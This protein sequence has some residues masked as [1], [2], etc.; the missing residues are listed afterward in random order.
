MI[1]WPN[2]Y[3]RLLAGGLIERLID[4]K[5]PLMIWDAEF[6]SLDQIHS[7]E[8]LD[9]QVIEITPFAVTCGGDYW[10]YLTDSLP[11]PEIVLCYWDSYEAEYFAKDLSQFIFRQTL[12]FSGN[13]GLRE[14]GGGWSVEDAKRIISLVCSDLGEFVP[15]RMCDKL[16]QIVNEPNVHT[17]GEWTTL[18]SERTSRQLTEE[19]VV[20]DRDELSFEWR[21]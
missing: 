21:E 14:G 19:L 1:D 20:L 5:D 3:R 13:E 8:R 12:A 2:D 9:D 6:L 10:A 17:A 16:R 15:E 7:F 18:I 4:P 11:S